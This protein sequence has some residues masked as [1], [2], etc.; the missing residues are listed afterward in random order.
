M[1]QVEII[2][3]DLYLIFNESNKKSPIIVEK[4]DNGAELNFI[5]DKLSSLMLPNFEQQLGQ[6]SLSGLEIK[7][8]DVHMD[9][10]TILFTL[11]IDGRNINGKIDCSSIK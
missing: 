1:N 11:N 6:G 10:F 8:T 9:D 2:N 4:L 7:L 3:G 5:D